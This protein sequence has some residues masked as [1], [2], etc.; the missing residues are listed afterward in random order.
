[1]AAVSGL[2]QISII[3]GEKGVG[4]SSIWM[5]ACARGSRGLPM[6]GEDEALCKPFNTLILSP[7]NRVRQ[8]ITPR[9]M[10]AGA[11]MKR[12]F[13]PEVRMK[14]GGKKAEHY[15]LPGAAGLIGELIEECKARFLIVDPITAFLEQNI[16]S[17][18]EASVRTG[19]PRWQKF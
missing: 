12:I 2:W 3:D 9:L 4:K 19:S 13:V 16:N 7:E 5:D 10:A 11:D 6:P 8:V 17:H 1:M 15:L 14:R 18:N